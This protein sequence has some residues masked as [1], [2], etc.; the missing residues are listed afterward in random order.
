M[1][2]NLWRDQTCLGSAS[3]T[4][5]PGPFL[6]VQW[7]SPA[8]RSQ[9]SLLC[10]WETALL[11]LL[12][13]AN[14][15]QSS[16]PACSQRLHFFSCTLFIVPFCDTLCHINGAVRKEAICILPP[17]V[18]DAATE[19]SM[20]QWQ[21]LQ[22]RVCGTVGVVLRAMERGGVAG[23][24]W[25]QWRRRQ[26]F[27]VVKARG[28]K[29]PVLSMCVLFLVLVACLTLLGHLTYSYESVRAILPAGT[30]TLCNCD[31]LYLQH[32]LFLQLWPMGPSS[33][34][35]A[36]LIMAACSFCHARDKSFFHKI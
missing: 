15:I 2:A 19:S 30:L 21:W 4:H 1:W 23:Q 32:L 9:G 18:S 34:H 29:G 27:W 26:Q 5:R 16:I 25:Q 7:W 31:P 17:G 36:A 24:V 20:H 3:T 35:F 10:F 12:L 6:G 14:G 8:S 33:L 13:C 28:R 11:V 22:M